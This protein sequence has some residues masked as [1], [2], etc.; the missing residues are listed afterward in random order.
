MKYDQRMF[1]FEYKGKIS[2]YTLDLLEKETVEWL[3]DVCRSLNV[4]PLCKL[5]IY[6][7]CNSQ[8]CTDI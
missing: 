6:P 7:V 8:T 2:Y 1:V 3:K 4:G 5:L